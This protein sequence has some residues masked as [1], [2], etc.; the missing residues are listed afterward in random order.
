MSAEPYVP[1]D[2]DL[3]HLRTAA[4]TGDG[5]ASCRAATKTVCR[6]HK[7]PGRIATVHPAA[8]LRAPDHADAY[9]D[10]ITELRSAA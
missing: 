1:P 6:S 5:C 10:F 8:I 2:A 4:H 7:T 9:T 3:D